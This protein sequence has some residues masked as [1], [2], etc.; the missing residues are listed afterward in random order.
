MRYPSPRRRRGIPTGRRASARS[1]G[2]GHV[3]ACGPVSW[4]NQPA[5]ARFDETLVCFKALLALG[6][7]FQATKLISSGL[8]RGVVSCLLLRVLVKF[9]SSRWRTNMRQL[10]IVSILESKKTTKLCFASRQKLPR[11]VTSS[12]ITKR[13]LELSRA[14]RV[15]A[16]GP[17]AATQGPGGGAQPGAV[18]STEQTTQLG[19]KKTVSFGLLWCPLVVSGVSL[20]R[21]N[22]FPRVARVGGSTAPTSDWRSPKALGSRDAFWSGKGKREDLRAPSPTGPVSMCQHRTKP[23][24]ERF[25]WREAQETGIRGWGLV[26]YFSSFGGEAGLGFQLPLRRV[27]FAGFLFVGAG[28]T[29]H[30]WVAGGREGHSRVG[31]R[32]FWHGESAGF[33]GCVALAV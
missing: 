10:T 2:S 6:H 28:L 19:R 5:S 8:A 4:V 26:P 21:P 18:P 31:A 20:C 29:P 9:V 3:G 22:L 11:R 23:L 16:G 25:C 32:G 30:L 17:G 13:A 15:G 27:F 24:E 33:R 14:T 12:R 1:L 7:L